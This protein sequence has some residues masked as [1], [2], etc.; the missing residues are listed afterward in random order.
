MISW[1]PEAPEDEK[2]HPPEQ[3][4]AAG[5]AA[6]H[7]SNTAY[8]ISHNVT[9]KPYRVK[10]EA[11]RESIAAAFD[12][13]DDFALYSHIPFCKTRCYFCEYTVVGRPE[14]D[15]GSEY[16]AL[17]SSELAAYRELLGPR[18]IHGFDIGGGTPSFVDA[19]LITE[20]VEE[21][22]AAFAAAPGFE[23]S[24]ET[25]PEIAASE[26][27]KIAE[28]YRAGIRR[29]SMGI[30]VVQPDLLRK[31][32]RGANGSDLERAASN[33]RAAGFTNFNVDVM[34]GFAGQSLES[35]AYTLE[36]ALALAPEA[37]TLYRMRYKL[38]RIS[39]EAPEVDLEH[40]RGH[41]KLASSILAA[42][43]Y[44][45]NPGKNTYT[46]ND[47]ARVNTGTS[48]YL[49]RRVIQGMPYLGLGLGAQTF[50]HTTIAY[51]DG[52]A[53]KSIGPYEKSLKAGRLPVQDH[54][55][56]PQIHMAAKMSA[57]SFYFG[58]INLDAFARKFG[59]PLEDMYADEVKFVLSEGLMEY[60]RSANGPELDGPK[61]SLS[62]TAEGARSFNGTIA[63]F[64]APSVQKVLLS[65]EFD[66]DR[67]R[68]A[69]LLV[70]G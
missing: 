70:A 2:R 50:T 36:R 45:A 41:A 61:E 25:T 29:I 1:K 46:R 31:F 52:A 26:P 39:A 33:I 48:G 18:R 58:E 54:Y 55:E 12:G 56:L 6:H 17:L 60:T 40:V 37:V 23:I 19:R 51:N 68:R 11:H 67:N 34:Y 14:L 44:T 30:Q 24:I 15:R 32:N 3:V 64:F 43:G 5:E 57:V 62:L 27:E 66:F 8:P 28:Y 59:R 49:S 4:F 9:W 10:R 16:M 65:G 47:F 63:L 21:V 38:T 7:V 22:L 13:I 35:L 42:A 69:A 53:S 20:H